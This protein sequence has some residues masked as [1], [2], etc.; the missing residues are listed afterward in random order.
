MRL[1]REEERKRKRECLREGVRR[2]KVSRLTSPLSPGED[3][4]PNYYSYGKPT[5]RA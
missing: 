2:R 3:G 1:A 4:H 5:D